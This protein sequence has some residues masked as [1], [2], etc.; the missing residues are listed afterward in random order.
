MKIWQRHIFGRLIKTFL[1]FLF[2]IFF[3]YIVVDLSVHGVR[4]LSSGK[5]TFTQIAVYYLQTFAI[6]LDLFLTLT[7][8]LATMR[9]LFDL[10]THRELVAL[11]MAGL[12]KKSLLAP[13]FFFAAFLTLACYI[14]SQW[15]AP[16]AQ[17]IAKAFMF[18]QKN[19]EEKEK[20]VHVYSISLED[21]S[22]L[23]Y[24]SF[25]RDQKELFDVFWVRTP[26][27]IWHMKYLEIK[28]LC[29]RFVTHLTRNGQ[30]QIEKS[31]SFASRDFPEIPWNE[32]TILQKFVP[33]QNRP[34]ST[35]F[36]Q[37]L[38]ASAERPR[39]LS[40]LYYKLLAPLMP[41]LVLFAIGPISIHFSRNQPLFLITAASLFGFIALK[42][43]LDGMLILG[44]NQVL[45]ATLAILG[46]IALALAFSLPSFIRMR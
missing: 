40:H 3:I 29:G 22:E 5:T 31:E 41:L 7:F 9:V 39:I 4:F 21:D 38:I 13:F 32:E 11:Q 10:N 23:V 8:L 28:P 46:P 24:Q 42:V 1:F 14:N 15:F 26:N 2:C 37:A 20:K 6:L 16:D 27:D 17:T 12:S 44:E 19:K 43:I 18:A 35:L 45:P 30:K 33:Y 25:D 34:I 36:S